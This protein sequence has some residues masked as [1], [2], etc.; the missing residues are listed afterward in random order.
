MKGQAVFSYTTF[1]L[2]FSPSYWLGSRSDAA[3]FGN[4]G[5]CCSGYV[6]HRIAVALRWGNQALGFLDS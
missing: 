4:P 2:Q 1:V 6:R 3:A 5:P